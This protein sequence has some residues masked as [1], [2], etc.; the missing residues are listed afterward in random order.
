MIDQV[1]LKE[2]NMHVYSVLFYK[3]SHMPVWKTENQ[4]KI[5]VSRPDLTA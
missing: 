2:S 3:E 4:Q 1:G 5:G